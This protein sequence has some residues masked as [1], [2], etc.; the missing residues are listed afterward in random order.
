MLI[1]VIFDL[2]EGNGYEEEKVE[3]EEKVEEQGEPDIE[4][5]KVNAVDDEINKARMHEIG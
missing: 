1:N 4:L 5:E 2:D 3:D